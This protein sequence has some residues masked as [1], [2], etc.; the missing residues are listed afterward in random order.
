MKEN[1]KKT[2]GREG[3]LSFVMREDVATNQV[4][5][6]SNP[7]GRAIRIRDQSVISFFLVP[8]VLPC[9]IESGFPTF[10]QGLNPNRFAPVRPLCDS[11]VSVSKTVS[12]SDS[13]RRY[14]RISTR[15]LSGK[16]SI[17]TWRACNPIWIPGCCTTIESVLIRVRCVVAEHQWKPWRTGNE[18]GRKSL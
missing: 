1:K 2:K 3:V 5:G 10:F 18:S 14:C 4:V 16:E 6:G 7:S 13:I 9:P 12:V 11:C 15:S 17:P 8:W